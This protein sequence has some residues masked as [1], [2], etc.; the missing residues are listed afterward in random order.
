[1]ARDLTAIFAHESA[2]LLPVIAAC[3]RIKADIVAADEREQGLRRVLNFG[4]TAGHA[5]EAV[6]TYRRFRHGEAIAYGMLVAAEVASARRALAEADRSALQ[7]LVVQ[8]GPLPPIGDLSARQVLEA[9]RR[10][11]KVLRARLHFVL[12]TAIGEATVV[13]DVT[14]AELARALK[15][16]GLQ[17]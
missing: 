11:K 16:V 10:D 8:M 9:M 12:P 13:D 4:H 2:V 14:E 7:R 6:T 17:R 3:C 1:V 5:L 15:K